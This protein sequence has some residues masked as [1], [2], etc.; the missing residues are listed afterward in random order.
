MPLESGIESPESEES[1]G[2]VF[3]APNDGPAGR[4]IHIGLRSG[5]IVVFVLVAIVGGFL[6]GRRMDQ[7]VVVP[8]APAATAMAYMFTVRWGRA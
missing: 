2:E 5:S 8:T 1:S 7:P 4:T 3:E 6:V